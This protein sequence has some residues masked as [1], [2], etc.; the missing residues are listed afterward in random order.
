MR[1]LIN[2]AAG[3]INR[4][5]SFLRQLDYRGFFYRDGVLRDIANFDAALMQNPRSV[6]TSNYTNNFIFIPR[7]DVAELVRKINGKSGVTVSNANGTIVDRPPRVADQM[8]R[9]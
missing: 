6:Y 7:E 2:S 1:G 9:L 4:T 8:Q 5:T 3:A